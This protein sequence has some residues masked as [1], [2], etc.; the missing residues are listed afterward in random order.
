MKGHLVLFIVIKVN[1]NSIK[2]WKF[3]SFM[4]LI[5]LYL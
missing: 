5:P 4:H 3:Y 2:N 1:L